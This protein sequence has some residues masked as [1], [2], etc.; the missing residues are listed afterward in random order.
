MTGQNVRSNGLLKSLRA[1]VARVSLAII[2]LSAL[3]ALTMTLVG[4]PAVQADVYGADFTLTVQG[5]VIGGEWNADV[6]APGE[7]NEATGFSLQWAYPGIAM[8][9]CAYSGENQ[10]GE[11]VHRFPASGT[12]SKDDFTQYAAVG[13]SP[14]REYRF[15][16]C[17]VYGADDTSYVIGSANQTTTNPGSVTMFS[18]GPGDGKAIVQWREFPYTSRYVIKWGVADTT[19]DGDPYYRF[20]QDNT[21]LLEAAQ[22]ATM[23]AN[24][25]C[26][27]DVTGLTNG[28]TYVARVVAIKTRA[29]AIGETA[30]Q[31]V[32]PEAGTPGQ[33][34]VT[35]TGGSQQ[36]TATWTAD[37]NGNT[38]TDY[39]VQYRASWS[40][41]WSNAAHS[42]A[43]ASA[44]ISGL[45]HNTKYYVRVRATNSANT[46][47][48]SVAASART[49]AG[50]PEKPWVTL[51]VS[52]EQITAA[53]EYP[54]DNG[55]SITSYTVQ[56][57][58]STA[59]S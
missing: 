45:Q 28:T 43:T 47:A 51:T 4:G 3:T 36:V 41:N 11:R 15:R 57:K 38:I 46:G 26:K 12:L 50:L 29:G 16:L 21:V 33:P 48:W 54:I 27:A 39:D 52:D 23:C 59:S 30:P 10:W 18:V 13:L 31:S 37:A 25:Y 20:V 19:V 53:W 32:T 17:G 14:N 6:E 1:P 7:N 49:S 56:H 42:G 9:T 5:T 24:D 55:A 44:T 22:I 58:L 34:S 2:A 40:R 8:S 35:L